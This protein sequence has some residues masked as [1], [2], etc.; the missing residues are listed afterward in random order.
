MK[1]YA[2][3]AWVTLIL[4]A[5]CQQ[6]EEPVQTGTLT[7]EMKEVSFGFNT[8][9]MELPDG[10]I[11]GAAA[12]T[13]RA[14]AGVEAVEVHTATTA[15]PKEQGTGTR[16][17]LT[18][19]QEQTVNEVC[20]YQ[21]NGTGDAAL[22]VYKSYVA[23]ISGNST[24]LSLL[25]GTDQTVY[26]VAN[27]GDRT[28]DF[29]VNTTTLAAFR[30][31]VLTFTESTLV[32]GSDVPAIGYY[33]G[34]TAVASIP[35]TL[36][37]LAARLDL[38]C[39]LSLPAGDSFAFTSITLESV[40]NVTQL[41][42]PAGN[43]PPNTAGDASK[44]TDYNPVTSYTAGTTLTWYVPENLR[45]TVGT[46]TGS[47]QKTTANAPAYSTCLVVSGTYT[48]NG[49]TAQEVS[50]FIYPGVNNTTDFNLMRNRKYGITITLK[51]I[52]TSDGRVVV[53][54]LGENLSASATANCYIVKEGG[55][56]YKFNAT[57]MGN[58]A[59]TPAST[60]VSASNGT[61]AAPAITPTALA[62]TAAFVVWETGGTKGGVI[63]DGSVTLA[64]GY[65][66]FKTANNSTPGNALIAVTDGTNILWSW[67]IWKVNY[68]PATS[69]DTYSR[70]PAGSSTF[71]MMKYNLGATGISN[72][73]STATNAG[74]MG[75]LYQWGRKDPFVGAS[76]WSDTTPVTVT[77]ASGYAYGTTAN[78]TAGANAA[79]SITYSVKNPTK[80][81]LNAS[82]TNDWLNATAYTA[83]RDNL[84]G[85]PNATATQPNSAKG[86]KSIYDPCP[87]GW[88]VP[89]QESYQIFTQNGAN[90]GTRNVSALGWTYGWTFYTQTYLSGTTSYWPAL[91]YRDKS[92][93]ALASVSSYGGYW[94][95]SS[96][97]SGYMDV[98]YLYFVSSSVY[99]LSYNYRGYAFS[100]R[101]AQE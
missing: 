54:G 60:I 24:P 42:A 72:W 92:T 82:T 17:A 68:D 12:A 23:G 76:G 63:E 95:S 1:K 69:Y 46:I 39:N 21:F 41:A 47:W 77:Y 3:L 5:S 27:A 34:S 98:G 11:S 94:S 51:G 26:V 65:V 56:S 67:H 13:T 74:D 101:C 53:G 66:T 84:W 45:G 28:A 73:S 43:Y 70:Y 97:A 48:P 38:T 30:A 31:S 25:I 19:T 15:D 86:S 50:Y 4:L 7:G 57:V 79:A 85:N 55:K 44:Y 83:Q 18:T 6:Q 9:A 75:L 61:Q 16:A 80:F 37:R 96:Y 32:A 78:A 59:T 58:G 40:P 20:L 87:P 14:L 52:N 35:V 29:T 90:G 93:G 64:N 8:A 100:V 22:L 89:S 81:I 71:K 36:T 33:T 88:R 99:P 91:G 10:N 49:G 62:P 2:I